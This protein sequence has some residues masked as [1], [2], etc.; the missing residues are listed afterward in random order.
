MLSNYHG[1]NTSVASIRKQKPKKVFNE[2]TETPDQAFIMEKVIDWNSRIENYTQ[3]QK[4]RY[5]TALAK[6]AEFL[7]I[8]KE[9][10]KDW[11]MTINDKKKGLICEQKVSK[12]GYAIIRCKAQ[13][14]CDPLTAWRMMIDG[15]YRAKY[16]KNV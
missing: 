4:N 6:Q 16:D 10:S 1:N 13:F 9:P 5:A 11:T 15:N 8:L 12:L 2:I 14:D 3:A 7:E